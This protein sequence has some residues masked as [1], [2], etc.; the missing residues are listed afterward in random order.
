MFVLAILLSTN[1]SIAG[2]KKKTAAADAETASWRYEV[3]Q[4]SGV[5]KQGCVLLAVWSYSKSP[6]IAAAQACKNAVHAVVYKGVAGSGNTITRKPL[7]SSVNQTP[8]EK[9]YMD[10]FFAT[11]G[12]YMSFVNLTSNGIPGT[13]SVLKVSNKEYKV[14]VVVEVNSEQLRI[15]LEKSGVIRGLSSGF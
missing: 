9:A 4:R 5:A 7:L 6:S 11:G 13:N 1:L 8:E 2:S 15:A 10:K 12:P 3:T 14:G